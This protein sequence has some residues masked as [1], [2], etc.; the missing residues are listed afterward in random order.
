M[1]ADC[2]LLFPQTIIIQAI[3]YDHSKRQMT[4][5]A[6]RATLYTNT[7]LELAWFGLLKTTNFLEKNSQTKI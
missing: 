4:Y 1:V 3:N 7:I 6:V 2:K 5:F